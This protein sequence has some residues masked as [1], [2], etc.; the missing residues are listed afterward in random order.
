MPAG[1]LTKEQSWSAAPP[2]IRA[3]GTA[4]PS[5]ETESVLPQLGGQ[6]QLPFSITDETPGGE[7]PA[8]E[9]HEK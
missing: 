9:H 8:K 7:V 1:G 4:Q 5:R 6:Q 2:P 3:K